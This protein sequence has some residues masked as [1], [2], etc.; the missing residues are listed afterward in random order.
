VEHVGQNQIIPINCLAG[1]FLLGVDA[2]D[3]FA[4]DSQFRHFFLPKNN[5]SSRSSSSS[6]MM[7]SDVGRFKPF[8]AIVDLNGLKLLNVLTP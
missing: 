7:S 8:R 6:R 5:R 2:L 3:R 1:D 4:Y